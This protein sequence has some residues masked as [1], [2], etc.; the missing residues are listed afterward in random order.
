MPIISKAKGEMWRKSF[1]ENKN[2]KPGPGRGNKPV[3]VNSPSLVYENSDKPKR[4]PKK[5]LE[6]STVGEVMKRAD[7]SERQAKQCKKRS[8]YLPADLP[9]WRYL[10]APSFH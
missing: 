5:M 3:K 6:N 8:G 4:D 9:K 2:T 10:R 7:V 1:E